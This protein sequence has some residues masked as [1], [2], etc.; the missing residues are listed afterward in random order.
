[1]FTAH[2]VPGTRTHGVIIFSIYDIFFISIQLGDWLV[3]SLHVVPKQILALRNKSIN[4]YTLVYLLNM[5]Q[6]SNSAYLRLLILQFLIPCKVLRLIFKCRHIV[7]AGW[8]ANF[9]PF[10]RWGARKL[11]NSATSRGAGRITW[12]I[13]DTCHLN[14]FVS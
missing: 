14:K 1:M 13:H 5:S 12:I 4:N 6:D 3:I 10:S 11:N 2:H 7:I 9:G 8:A